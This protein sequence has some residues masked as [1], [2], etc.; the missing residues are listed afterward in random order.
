MEKYKVE[1]CYY[2]HLHGKA[3]AAKVIG[4]VRGIEYQL[5]SSDYLGFKPVV[6]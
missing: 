4:N 1:K 2:G 6:V 5:I 3:Q